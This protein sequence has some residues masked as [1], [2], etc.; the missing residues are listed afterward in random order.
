VQSIL[1][2]LKKE[3]DKNFSQ[4]TELLNRLRAIV[5]GEDNTDPAQIKAGFAEFKKIQ[6]EW[7]SA[8]NINSPHNNTL[9]QT[10]HALVDRFYSNRSI[11][12]ELLSL[13]ENVIFNTKLNFVQKSKK[14]L[15]PLNQIP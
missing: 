11:Y 12:F 14:L 10:Y 2:K 8:G 15:K 5:E 13:T 7:K 4:K 6:D 1:I 9:W 3:R